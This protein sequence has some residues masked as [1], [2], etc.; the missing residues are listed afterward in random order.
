MPAT[1]GPELARLSH[2]TQPTIQSPTCGGSAR[3]PVKRGIVV[4]EVFDPAEDD[5]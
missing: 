2:I 5:M 1:V 4:P 3:R